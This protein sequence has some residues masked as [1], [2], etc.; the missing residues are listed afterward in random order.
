MYLE[1][2]SDNQFIRPFGAA[3]VA[4]KPAPKPMPIKKP[5]YKAP[6]L[7]RN[8][9]PPVFAPPPK[10]KPRSIFCNCMPSP[11]GTPAC[12]RSSDPIYA[13]VY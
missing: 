3:K 8:P 6:L 5:I 7:D 1:P 12:C 11:Q 13:R 4:P 9:R 10:P 2:F